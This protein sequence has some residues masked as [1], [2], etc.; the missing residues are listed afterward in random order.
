MLEDFSQPHHPTY[1]GDIFGLSLGYFCDL[2]VI[3]WEFFWDIF[4][5]FWDLSRVFLGFLLGSLMG[6]FGTFFYGI[7][8]VYPAIFGALLSYYYLLGD[9]FA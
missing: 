9:T 1:L 2:F 7:F 4:G 8:S 3:F 5:A 6:C